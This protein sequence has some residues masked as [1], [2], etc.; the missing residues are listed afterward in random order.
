MPIRGVEV[1][2]LDIPFSEPLV[3][4]A[5]TWR[6]RRVGIVA[7]QADDGLVGLGE[8]ATETPGGLVDAHPDVLATRLTERLGDAAVDDV[9]R[10]LRRLDAMVSEGEIDQATR[11]AVDCAIMDLAARARQLSV[12]AMMA[13]HQEMAQHEP[14]E[15]LPGEP[16]TAVAVNALIGL[17]DPDAVVLKARTLVEAGFHCLKLKGAD[18]PGTAVVD[19][20]AATR[21]AVG[22]DVALRLD[23]NG[24]LDSDAATA[25]VAALA[26]Y[27]LQY[28]EQ[29]IAASLGP[30][31]LGNLRGRVDVPIAADEAVDGLDA[32]FALIAAEAVDVIVVKPAR[33]GGLSRAH[34]IA[35][36]AAE[37]GVPTVV[38]TLFETGIGVAGGLQ[39]AATLPGGMAH[40]LATAAL[41][42]SDLVTQRPAIIKGHMRLPV[43]AGLGVT[44]DRSA[45]AAYR[46]A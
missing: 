45:V 16:A 33:V 27:D 13:A 6:S 42:A 34:Q 38:S 4:A 29:P 19:R 2:L 39:L 10:L 21:G 15:P 22:P 7:L 37:A 18:E 28:V 35:D 44:L 9:P 17:G 31:A 5:G 1:E 20:V 11:S 24:S 8:I 23:L 43:E 26:P 46:A 30:V 25:L 3:T 40:G 14:A 36:R 41:L 32:A 12:A